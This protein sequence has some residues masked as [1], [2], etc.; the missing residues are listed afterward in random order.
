MS[1]KFPCHSVQG[2]AQS[3]QYI[4]LYIFT[5]AADDN[6]IIKIIKYSKIKVSHNRQR[7]P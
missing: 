1:T 4:P 3:T 7:L 5:Y 6:L 2:R